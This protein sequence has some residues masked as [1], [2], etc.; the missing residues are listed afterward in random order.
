MDV[1]T[2][3]PG[4]VSRADCLVQF[5]ERSYHASDSE[6]SD[7]GDSAGPANEDDDDPIVEYVD[8]YGRDRKAR[9]SEVPRQF[10]PQ[11]K[12]EEEEYVLNLF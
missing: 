9:R 11:D 10:L 6:D 3:L 12:E 5:E 2:A 4:R 8:E 1:S 7:A